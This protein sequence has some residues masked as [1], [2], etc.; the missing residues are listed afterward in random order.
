M[1]Q[2]LADP[3]LTLITA[4]QQVYKCFVKFVKRT[5]QASINFCKK[6]TRSSILFP[7]SPSATFLPRVC[8]P[9][10]E[11]RSPPHTHIDVPMFNHAWL[12]H[13]PV[14]TTGSCITYHQ[15]S[16]IC[17]FSLGPFFPPPPLPK[18]QPTSTSSYLR[19]VQGQ[20]R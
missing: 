12:K 17:I 1:N 7:W 14:W 5:E 8:Y 9:T 13:T 15:G 2:G 18:D 19:K 4:P 11:L 6:S 20:R 10:P 3:S 16:A